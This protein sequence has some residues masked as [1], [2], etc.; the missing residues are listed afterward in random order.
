MIESATHETQFPTF[1]TSCRSSGSTC[2]VFLRHEKANLIN[3][4]IGGKTRQ[5]S[6]VK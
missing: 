5:S 2:T 4:P 1:K 6:R 3:R